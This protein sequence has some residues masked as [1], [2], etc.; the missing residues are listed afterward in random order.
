MNFPRV[1]LFLM[2]VVCAGAG[3]AGRI[4]TARLDPAQPNAGLGCEPGSIVALVSGG[5]SLAGGGGSIG[6]IVLGCRIIG[7]LNNGRFTLNVSPFRQQVIKGGAI[8]LAVAIDT[9]HAG[10]RSAS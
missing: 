6:G 2:G 5:T 4:V 9:M 10:E 3:V 7:V 8:L 1:V